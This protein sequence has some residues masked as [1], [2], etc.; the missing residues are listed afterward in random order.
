MVD[1]NT[2]GAGGG[3]IAWID[4]AGG[5]RVGP[6]SAGADPGPACY[7]QGGSRATVT[8]ASVVLGYL[9]P[10]YFAAGRL[11]LDARLAHEAVAAVAG[12][13]GLDP[14]AAAAGIHRVVNARMADQIRLVTIERGFD[15]RGFALV[16]LGGAGPVHGVALAEELALETVIVPAAPGVL[17][18]FGL[19]VAAIEHAQSRTAVQDLRAPD[20]AAIRA[21]LAELDAQG[22]EKM[23]GERVP[24]EAVEVAFSADMRYVG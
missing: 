8:D 23:R 4:G 6:E 10:E 24:V 7:G 13:L 11:R 2:I 12:P 20:C 5:L 15:P 3:S 14:V 21:T 16:L 1:V 17:S 22:R 18:A 19:L 9:N